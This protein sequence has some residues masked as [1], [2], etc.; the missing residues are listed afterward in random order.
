MSTTIPIKVTA[1][2]PGN[3]IHDLQAIT[4]METLT[5]SLKMAVEHY[6]RSQKLL[7]LTENIKKKPLQFRK[8]FSAEKIRELNRRKRW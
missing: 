1:L 6:V 2:L 8:G 3:L 4:Q 5:E 7:Q